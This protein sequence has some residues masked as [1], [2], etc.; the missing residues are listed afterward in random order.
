[1]GWFLEASSPPIWKLLLGRLEYTLKHNRDAKHNV[2]TVTYKYNLYI[3]YIVHTIEL[4]QSDSAHKSH[5]NWQE[6]RNHWAKELASNSKKSRATTGQEKQSNST[7][8]DNYFLQPEH[9]QLWAFIFPNSGF[10]LYPSRAHSFLK[11]IILSESS[12]QFPH[13][14]ENAAE[15]SELAKQHP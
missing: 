7:I 1:M 8:L 9:P 14:V 11:C 2:I 3:Q 15:A 5:E 10:H 6:D 4:T 12:Q 13:E